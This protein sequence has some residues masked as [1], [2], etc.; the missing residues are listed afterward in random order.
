MKWGS[1]KRK[2]TRS[3]LSTLIEC[4][5]HFEDNEAQ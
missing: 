2:K 4:I 1:R 3:N 5:D